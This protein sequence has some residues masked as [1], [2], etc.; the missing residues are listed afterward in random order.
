MPLSVTIV[1]PHK[2]VVRNLQCDELVLPA[3]QGEI[4]VLPGHTP[5]L[6]TLGVGMIQ[7]L[8]KEENIHFLVSY[9][10]SEIRDDQVLILGE[11]IKPATDLDIE[12][13][14]KAKAEV[15]ETAMNKILGEMEYANYLKKLEYAH[16]ELEIAKLFKQKKTKK[17]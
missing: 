13:A 11:D 9:G 8:S 17:Q 6:T 1:T 14:E 15:E 16:K 5:L 10:F 12:L 2:K 4:T 7:T 3:A